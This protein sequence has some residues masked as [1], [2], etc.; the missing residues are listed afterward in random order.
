MGIRSTQLNN[1]LRPHPIYIYNAWTSLPAEAAFHVFSGS[2]DAIATL[3]SLIEDGKMLPR[4]VGRSAHRLVSET[5]SSGK[6]RRDALTQA[7]YAFG[8]PTAW[9]A[10]HAGV[11]VFDSGISYDGSLDAI[12]P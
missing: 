4:T 2:E 8:L 11:F 5:A 10:Q 7:V 6:A 9:I 3:T 12:A 1:Q